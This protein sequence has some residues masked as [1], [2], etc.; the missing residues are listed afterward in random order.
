MMD[1]IDELWFLKRDIVSDDYDRAL[2]RLAE[3]VPM[4]IH[5]YPSGEECWTWTVPEKWTCHEAYLETLDG[6]RIIDY[7]DHPLHVVSYSLPYE[8]VVSRSELFEHLHVSP[9][10]DDAIPFAFKYYQRDWGLCMSKQMK[11][12]LN[13]DSY[14][15]VIRSTFEKG[16]LKVG[17]VVLEGQSRESFMLDA[18]L[19]HPAMVSDD[20]SGVVLG[21]DVMRA[22][23]EKYSTQKPYYTYRMLIV[24][25]TIGSL[26]YLS[27]H[28]SLI[29]NMVGGLFLESLG[30]DSPHALQ[31]SFVGTNLGRVPQVDLCMSAAMKGLDPQAYIGPYRSVVKNDEAQ[32][33]APG[34]RVAMLSLS[35]AWPNQP[36]TGPFYF[37]YHSSHDTP[38]IVSQERMEASRDLVL[39]LLDAWEK[40]QYV[41]NQFKGEIF[42]SRYGIWVD[43]RTNPEGWR[44]LFQIMEY[45]D[46]EH[47][48]ADIAEKLNTSFKTV[49]EVVS[50][51]AEKHLVIFSRKPVVTDP[52]R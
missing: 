26:A 49:W 10:W 30:I 22:L 38:A 33:N 39:A 7:A 27:H 51:L 37:G 32:F 36:P 31:K 42:C 46:G 52:H 45:C 20:L 3:E 12:T 16:T 13:E 18:H 17:E 50:Q 4:T 19:C 8:G 29:P 23:F 40:N 11:D 44:L 6:R 21:V 34:V 14:R 48:V 24:P 15:V 25:E 41:V 47:T 9:F 5:E 35:R 1:L 2:Y 28:E 43:Y